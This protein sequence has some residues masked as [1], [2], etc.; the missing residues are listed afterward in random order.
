MRSAKGPLKLCPPL[1][2]AALFA[3]TAAA[4]FAEFAVS[5]DGSKLYFSSSLPLQGSNE[6]Q[7]GRIFSVDAGG[8]HSV[9]D[10]QAIMPP[11]TPNPFPAGQTFTNYFQLSRPESSRDGTIVIY[12]GSRNCYGSSQCESGSVFQT[13]LQTTINLPGGVVKDAFGSGR[14]SGN[15][16]YLLLRVPD[17]AS[18][19]TLLDLQTGQ[20]QALT[21]TPGVSGAGRVVADDGTIAYGAGALVIV[22]ATGPNR[23][24]LPGVYADQAVIDANAHTVVYVTFDYAKNLHA[25][26]AYSIAQQK[27]IVLF[28]QGDSTAPFLSADGT[29][30]MFVSTASGSPQIWVI[31]TDG[32][33]A[34]QVTSDPAG[35]FSAAMSDD[36]K[37]A[38]YLSNSARV[39]QVD[40]NSGVAQERIARTAN[41]ATSTIMAP[42]SAWTLEGTGFSDVTSSAF[43]YPLP[44]TLGGVSVSIGGMSAPI[45][46]VGATQIVVQVPWEIPAV[47]FPGF[48]T[49]VV[50]NT[51]SSSPFD[52]A[53]GL[54]SK[55]G[56]WI[57]DGAFVSRP[58]AD[59]NYGGDYALAVHQD[60]SALVTPSNPARA[61]EIV[62]LYGLDF[63]PVDSHPATGMP[64]TASPLSRTVAPITCWAWGADNA[65]KQTVPVLFSG[66]VPGVAGYYQLDV[67]LP[68]SNLRPDTQISCTGSGYDGGFFGDVP[69]AQ[70]TPAAPAPA[71]QARPTPPRRRFAGSAL[72]NR[73]SLPDGGALRTGPTRP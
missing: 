65:T 7:Q 61:N 53:L 24:S 51:A 32:T 60:W 34:R 67:Q 19:L 55:A 18:S 36:G 4:Q 43:S 33:G 70:I 41:W 20:S 16:R 68:T 39:F 1:L 63:G 48:S 28:S 23:I 73:A 26:H 2:L 64:A 42:G 22:G 25:I 31:N 8:V 21:P 71:A 12:T 49:S 72:K 54:T 69:V 47:A 3:A 45:L 35:V 15:G 10:V 6:P 27:D 40:L 9:A 62:H 44:Q 50:V 46:S 66:L 30:A 13:L 14:I 29:R 59:P 37:M 38:W 58:E 52:A 57:G 17:P 11:A 5:G 56:A